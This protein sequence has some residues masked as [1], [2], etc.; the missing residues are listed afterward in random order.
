MPKEI[1]TR[2][3]RFTFDGLV[4]T[5]EILDE[6]ELETEDVIENRQ[7]ALSIT[8]QSRYLSLV[9]AAPYSTITH[10]ARKEAGEP[11]NYIHTIAQA[12]VVKNLA[13]RILGNFF[14]R[15]HRPPC[16]CRLFNDRAA[17]LSW[18]M[19]FADGNDHKQGS[20]GKMMAF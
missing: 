18:L 14:L 17:A 4:L 13:S 12:I 11:S 8:G 6:K 19:E 16:P 10:E 15:F 7:A 20:A 9:I 3:V 2:T 1:T 5:S